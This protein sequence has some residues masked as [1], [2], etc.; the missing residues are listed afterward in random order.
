MN[1]YF[2]IK[3]EKTSTELYWFKMIELP[4]IIYPPWQK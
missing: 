3:N 2:Y 4:L 1:K